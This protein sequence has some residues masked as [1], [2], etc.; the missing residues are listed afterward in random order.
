MKLDAIQSA[1]FAAYD[2][3]NAMNTADRRRPTAN[4]NFGDSLAEVIEFLEH[5][6]VVST[7]EGDMKC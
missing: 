1:L 5:L 3:R 4:E 2:L 7:E 6:E